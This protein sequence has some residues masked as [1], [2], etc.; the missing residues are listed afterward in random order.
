M[1][2]TAL[3]LTLE[4]LRS[5]RPD[6][7]PTLPPVAEQRKQA[8]KLARTAAR[9]LR[10]QFGATRVVAFGSLVRD[11]GFSRWS[12]VDLAAQGIPAHQ[13]FSAV[14]AVTAISQDFR[15]EL[16]DPENCRS[17]VHQSIEREGIDL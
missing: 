8:W 4:E 5:Y 14:A 15:V 12:D 7:K 9:I 10:E 3:D 2:R 13:F 17:S 11:A 6:R 16:V 1:A